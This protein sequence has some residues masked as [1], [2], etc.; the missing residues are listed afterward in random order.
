ML[1]QDILLIY[2]HKNMATHLSNN[3]QK[4][5]KNSKLFKLRNFKKE[6]L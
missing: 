2:M 6:V 4:K 1:V 3:L 5:L